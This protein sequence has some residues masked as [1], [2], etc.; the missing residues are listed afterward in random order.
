MVAAPALVAIAIALA[1]VAYVAVPAAE[2]ARAAELV[3]GDA[4]TA[5]AGGSEIDTVVPAVPQAEPGAAPA[6]G[7][8][9]RADD[10]T[11]PAEAAAAEAAQPATTPMS[12]RVGWIREG[13]R[14]AG[15][16]RIG[17]TLAQVS[18]ALEE[19]LVIVKAATG[20]SAEFEA[21]APDAGIRVGGIR[22]KV[23]TITVT[24]S[25]WAADRWK[26]TRGVRIDTP[27]DAVQRQYPAADPI[28][29]HEQ[30]VRFDNGVTMQ[31]DA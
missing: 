17:M 29:D 13:T 22:G 31:Y 27:V 12:Q 24:N 14:T 21:M 2:R 5:P 20:G 19:E 1:L 11:V 7:P 28:C 9:M 10:A 15:P 16:L 25:G 26:T 6:G 23:D 18:A 8:V 4:A 30:W 3:A